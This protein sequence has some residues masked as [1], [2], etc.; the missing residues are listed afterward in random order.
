[1]YFKGPRGIARRPQDSSRPRGT[2][3]PANP[4]Y[5]PLTGNAALWAASQW[6]FG[7]NVMYLNENWGQSLPRARPGL[8]IS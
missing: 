1:M 4:S 5:Q 6:E 3:L 7:S 8:H 2:P